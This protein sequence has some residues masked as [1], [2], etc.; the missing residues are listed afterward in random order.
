TIFL[1]AFVASTEW[2]TAVAPLIFAAEKQLVASA[3]ET[4]DVT[5][6][7]DDIDRQI[8]KLKPST[9]PATTSVLQALEIRR[10][11][12]T[13]KLWGLEHTNQQLLDDIR[14]GYSKLSWL[15]VSP[16]NPERVQITRVTVV[17]N[18]ILAA[19]YGALGTC[20]FLLR[21]TFR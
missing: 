13:A 7:I 9:T 15:G 18:F 16:D 17:V 5:V 11:E 8:E 10:D 4:R 20:V 19:L 21:S 3:Q 6:R 1:I 14:A 2:I 12:L